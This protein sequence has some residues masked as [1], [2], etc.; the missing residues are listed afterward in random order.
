MKKIAILLIGLLSLNAGANCYVISEDHPDLTTG[1]NAEKL[2]SDAT[3]TL[4][5]QY[6]Y[7]AEKSGLTLTVTAQHMYAVE[8]NFQIVGLSGLIAEGSGIEY[9]YP[10]DSEFQIID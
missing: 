8:M 4:V 3:Y 9:W 6:G 10:G 5:T 2:C 1:M 7:D